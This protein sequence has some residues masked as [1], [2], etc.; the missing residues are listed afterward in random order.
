MRRSTRPRPADG[1]QHPR[2][3]TL[4]ALSPVLFCCL[5]GW[6]FKGV[7]LQRS[8]VVPPVL[9]LFSSPFFAVPARYLTETR[10]A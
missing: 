2:T 6:C 7:C 10:Q 3:Q 9:P 4:R 5:S 1:S 8:L